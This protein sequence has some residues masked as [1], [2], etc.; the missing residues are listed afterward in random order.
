MNES[1][2][3]TLAFMQTCAL[4]VSMQW[5]CT[6]SIVQWML[7]GMI[8]ERDHDSELSKSFGSISYDCPTTGEV[9]ILE[10]HQAILI[11]HPHNNILCPMQM[12]MYEIKVNDI[13]KYFTENTTY[14]K[15]SIV[16]HVQWETLLIPLHLHGVTSYFTSRKPTTE[17]YN[18]CIHLSATSVDLEWDPY[19][20]SF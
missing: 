5:L 20:P 15:H 14:Q 16:M 7:L 18:N 1:N 12:R 10:V 4:L 17:E 9:F 6:I 13:P 8:F 2:G 19:D 3:K 11:Y